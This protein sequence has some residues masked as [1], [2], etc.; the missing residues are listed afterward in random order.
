[1]KL[2]LA[3]ISKNGT[4]NQVVSQTKKYYTDDWLLCSMLKLTRFA[5]RIEAKIN[6]MFNIF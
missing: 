6:L 2:G 3:K 5:W 1:M 4:D